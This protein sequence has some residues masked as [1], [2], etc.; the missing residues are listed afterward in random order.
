MIRLLGLSVFLGSH[1]GE[2]VA[3]K[4][5]ETTAAFAIENH[6]IVAVLTYRLQRRSLQEK[7]LDAE[8]ALGEVTCSASSEKFKNRIAGML[9]FGKDIVCHLKHSDLS[10]NALLEQQR[11]I[12]PTMKPRML[13]QTSWKNKYQLV[14]GVIVVF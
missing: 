9:D 10:T 7:V 11:K 4:L 8:C 3:E 2:Q 6:T 1:T 5:R 13:I 12:N 14:W